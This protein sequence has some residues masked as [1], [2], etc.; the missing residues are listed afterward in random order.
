MKLR[1]R[2]IR[3]VSVRSSQRR[4]SQRSLS[5]Q[6]STDNTDHGSQQEV[7]QSSTI[8][9]SNAPNAVVPLVERVT[10]GPSKYA[11]IW[12]LPENQKIELPLTSNNQPVK[13]VGRHFTGWLGTIARKPQMCPIKYENWTRMPNEFKEEI[14]NLVQSKWCLPEEPTRLKAMKLMTLSTVAACWRNHKSR[15]KKKYFLGSGNRA[16]VPPNVNPEDYEAIVQHWNLPKTKDLALKNKNI[17]SKQ[18]NLHTGGSKNFASY[19]EELVTT[20]GHP[21]ERAELYL[22]LHLR[23]DGAPVNPEAESNIEKI[24][25]LMSEPSNRL[26]S[27]DLTGSI[28]WAPDDIYSQ[29]FGN[30][31][32]GRV[33]GVGFGPTPSG[34]TVKNAAAITQIGSQERDA[35]VTQLRSQVALLT[36]KITRYDN[37]EERMTQMASMMQLMQNHFSEVSRGAFALDQQSPTPHRSQA[38]SHQETSFSR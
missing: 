26:Q 2:V 12:N 11:Y 20:L 8:D 25:E 7:G 23:K 4:P 10:R 37:L 36:E 34:R 16:Q 38:S 27:T 22:K 30:E 19:S 28:A 18:K 33:R 31:R 24:N 29:V 9:S 21:V 6:A 14:W 3:D 5:Q 1:S 13:K 32:N 15:L 17:R 35:E